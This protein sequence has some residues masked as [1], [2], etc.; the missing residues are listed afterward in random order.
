MTLYYRH[1]LLSWLALYF[2]HNYALNVIVKMK[3]IIYD[4]TSVSSIRSFSSRS[5]EIV[6][7]KGWSI[8][9]ALK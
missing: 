5:A 2:D 9:E 7:L 4:I 3:P 1:N 6:G 8:M